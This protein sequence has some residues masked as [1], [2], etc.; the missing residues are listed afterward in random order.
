MAIGREGIEVGI[1]A[2]PIDPEW[3][4]GEVGLTVREAGLSPGVYGALWKKGGAF[5]I[6]IS[7]DCP[8][9]GH[10]RFS[11][12]H[13]LGHYH[14]DGHVEAMFARDLGTVESRGGLFRNRK[15]PCEREA[16]WFASELLVPTALFVSRV[17]DQDGGI[18]RIRGLADE[19]E[20]SLSMMA[21]RYAE[22][23]TRAV[24]SILSRDGQIEWAAFSERIREHDWSWDLG[25]RDV[26]PPNT[27]TS[28]MV[29]HTGS[30]SR[31]TGSDSGLACEW[32]EGAPPDLE[33]E[34][35][36]ISL[37]SFG[38]LLTLLLIPHLPDPE[39]LALQ[40]GDPES[41]DWRDALRGY[42]M[43]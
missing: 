29:G 16:D 11:V 26:V 12:A 30:L 40:S 22:V 14:I 32:F 6:I 5:G 39:E 19:F 37:G 41:Q 3:I 36:V 1:D 27:A 21:I 4:A 31:T 18:E 33:L 34:E 2:P 23:T 10:R 15:D 38:R 43:G 35:D 28:R 8:T 42:R 24:A 13:E 7:P 20:T 25:K 17:R 9:V